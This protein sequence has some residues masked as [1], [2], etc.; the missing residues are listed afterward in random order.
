MVSPFSLAAIVVV[1]LA[2]DAR[3]PAY[4][5][6]TD[7][8]KLRERIDKPAPEPKSVDEIRAPTAVPKVAVPTEAREFRLIGAEITGSTVYSAARLGDFYEPYLGRKVSLPEVDA[9]VKAI[10]ENYRKDGYFLTRAIAPPQGVEFGVLRIRIIEG[11]IE[12]VSFKGKKPGRSGLF[13]SWTGRIKA[14]RPLK[15]ATLERNLLLMADIPGLTVIPGVK[16]IDAETGAYRLEIKLNHVRW[17]GFATLDNR[18]T[19][20]VGTLQAYTGVNFDSMLGL[21][22]STRLA[23]FTVPQTPEELRYI[24]FKQSHIL[25]SMGTQ[26]WFSASRSIVDTGIAGTTSKENSHGT[27]VTLGFSHPVIRSRENNLYLNLTL[28]IFE[29]D[30]NS[31]TDVF[32]DKLRI[33]RLGTIYSTTDGIGGTNWVF[34]EV[35]KG[36][37]IFGAIDRDSALTS[38]TGG[39][40]DF[41]QGD[42][43]PHPDPETDQA[44]AGGNNGLGSV[45]ATHLAVVRGILGRRATFWPGL[46]SCRH[47]RQSGA[48]RPRFR[49]DVANRW[50][51]GFFQGDPRPHPTGHR[52]ARYARFFP[53]RN[54]QPGKQSLSELDAGHFRVRQEFSDRRLRRQAAYSAARDDL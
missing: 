19:T 26:A 4:A 29:S 54:P 22:E 48:R 25:N 31:L 35:S 7:P 43:R 47:Q 46:R 18:G 39:R 20:P 44:V 24:E 3:H 14:E 41:F 28:D 53:S 23:V 15:L 45:V 21:L 13:E 34:A 12:E 49:T 33:A 27:R 17:N 16:P 32:D 30:K 11:Y 42:P 40:S 8:G 5:Q 51:V 10:T 38:R 50:P 6:A 2:V 52:Y 9:I 37:D 36:F 1:L